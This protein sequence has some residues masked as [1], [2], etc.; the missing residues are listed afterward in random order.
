[1]LGALSRH[2]FVASTRT[3]L[4]AE[5]LALWTSPPLT[6]ILTRC[7]ILWGKA[8]SLRRLTSVWSDTAPSGNFSLKAKQQAVLSN[9]KPWLF[10]LLTLPTRLMSRCKN[11]SQPEI[12]WGHWV[13]IFLQICLENSTYHATAWQRTV[14][15]ALDDLIYDPFLWSLWTTWWQKPRNCVARWCQW[16]SVRVT[17]PVC[18]KITTN[19]LAERFSLFQGEKK[20][21]QSQTLVVIILLMIFC[22]FTHQCDPAWLQTQ[23]CAVFLPAAKPSRLHLFAVERNNCKLS[24]I[25]CSRFSSVLRCANNETDVGRFPLGVP[26]DAGCHLTT[27]H[28]QA[29][30][31]LETFFLQCLD[32]GR[33]FWCPHPKT[34]KLKPKNCQRLSVTPLMAFHYPSP[35]IRTHTHTCRTVMALSVLKSARWTKK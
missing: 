7:D 8:H 23:T 18:L 28:R 14:C 10:V 16:R 27:P 32:R 34:S 15:A 20:K 19:V 26:S 1:M 9:P 33:D 17:D 29:E 21:R 13:N 2:L 12:E 11:G 5:Q 30:L 3:I 31:K 22:A 4:T 6:G 25:F 35:G 24:N